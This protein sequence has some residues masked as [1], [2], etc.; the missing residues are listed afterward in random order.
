MPPPKIDRLI[1]AGVT[2]AIGFLEYSQARIVERD[3]PE[4]SPHFVGMR[5]KRILDSVKLKNVIPY[6][7]ELVRS[8]DTLSSIPEVH[9]S[10]GKGGL[11]SLLFL[12]PGP[13]VVGVHKHLRLEDDL[14]LVGRIGAYLGGWDTECGESAITCY[15]H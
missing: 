13:L 2:E 9:E 5:T 8:V 1:H 11:R 6:R 3:H 10:Y 14:D 12:H 4:W 7:V 15:S